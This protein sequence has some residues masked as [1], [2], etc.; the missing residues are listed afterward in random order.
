LT[1]PFGK[2]D[3]VEATAFVLG[4]VLV[5][6]EHSDLEPKARYAMLNEWWGDEEKKQELIASALTMIP[7]EEPND[8]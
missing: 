6:K 7:P 3:I 2:L 1:V 8:E 4:R 5:M